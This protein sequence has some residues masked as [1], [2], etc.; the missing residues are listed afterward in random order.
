AAILT[1]PYRGHVEDASAFLARHADWLKRQVERLPEPIPFV[2]G[3]VVPVR[4]AF[5]HLKFAG[6]GRDQGVVWVEPSEHCAIDA[7]NPTYIDWCHLKAPLAIAASLPRLNINADHEF[8]ARR[9]S[10]WLRTEAK[11]DLARAVDR[12]CKTLSVAPKR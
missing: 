11:K 2:D 12:H 5:H 7:A 3:A 10:D 8:A 4:G 1:L 6:L 9:F